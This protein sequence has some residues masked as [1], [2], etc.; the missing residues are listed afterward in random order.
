MP[1]V[2]PTLVEI[3]RGPVLESVHRGHAVIT[4]TAGRIVEC[5]GDPDAVV[6][7]RSAVKMIQ[8]LPLIASGA[9]QA[10]G[11]TDRHLALACAS[12]Q[13]A[14]LHVDA[15]DAW[16]AD[17]RLDDGALVCGPQSSRDRALRHAMIKADQPPR[18]VHNN[19]S[20]KHAGFLTLSRHLG[21]AADYTDPAHPVQRAVFDA[22]ETVGGRPITQF[23]IDGCSAPNP[24]MTMTSLGRAMG[25]FAG[26]Q[27]RGDA[28]SAAG[29]RLVTAMIRHPDLVAGD[30]RACTLLMRAAGG[31]AALKTGAEGVFIAILPGRGLGVAVKIADGATRAAECAIAAILVRLGVLDKDH[32]DVARFL[33]PPVTNWDGLVTGHI[34]PAPAL[35]V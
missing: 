19:C 18:R 31:A 27:T 15:V 14:P 32:P 10:A 7:P 12:H 21:G 25:W 24:A 9:A 5:W 3:H 6:L 4:D 35:A 11:L 22:F 20:G 34:A 26:A 1:Q 33:A 23:G 8:A 16:L 2:P 30:G 29:A 13:G 17:L 28:L